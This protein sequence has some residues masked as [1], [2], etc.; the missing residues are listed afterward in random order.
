MKESHSLLWVPPFIVVFII[1]NN[2]IHI[3]SY[4]RHV[5]PFPLT[6][7]LPNISSCNGILIMRLSDV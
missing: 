3:W 4:A 7:F 2:G 1:V 6:L 5:T